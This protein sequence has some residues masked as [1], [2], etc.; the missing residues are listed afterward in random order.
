MAKNKI[1]KIED[2]DRF[3]ATLEIQND[4][5]DNIVL[6]DNLQFKREIVTRYN[7]YC[8]I[9]Y[10]NDPIITAFNLLWSHFCEM[11]EFNF[12]QLYK[13]LNKSYDPLANYDKHSTM[14][15]GEHVTDNVNGEQKTDITHGNITATLDKGGNEQITTNSEWTMESASALNKDRVTTT[16]NARVN[17]TVQGNDSSTL[18][19][20][21]DTTTSR[22]HIDE[23]YTRGNI[24]T[25]RTA[26]M[27]ADELRARET[28]L[29]KYI[30]DLFAQQ[31]LF[32][33]E[34]V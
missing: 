29:A 1:F 8:F 22:V 32:L 27:L 15:Y 4:H 9:G 18:H 25:T 24:G 26:E 34:G 11:N 13:A 31:Y 17:E 21:T 3:T 14:T 33:Y 20:Y 30:I 7:S 28:N 10:E 19:S 6:L 2:I 16:N 23:E 12:T 5:G